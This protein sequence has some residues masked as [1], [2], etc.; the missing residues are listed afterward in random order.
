MVCCCNIQK[1][2]LV[3]RHISEIRLKVHFAFSLGE[4]K[5]KIVIM[6]IA[7]LVFQ[8]HFVELRTLPRTTLSY[9]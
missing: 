7:Q 3:F 5:P 6:M 1:S 8:F 9:Y 4:T 2:S